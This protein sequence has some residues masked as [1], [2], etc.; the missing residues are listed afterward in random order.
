MQ[1]TTFPIEILIHDDAST[2]GTDDIIREYAEKYPEKI[3]PLFEEK[4]KYSSGYKGKMDVTFNY[5]R[6]RGKYIATCEGDD[7]WT[8]PL[9]LQKQVDFMEAHP[10]FS[11]CWHRYRRYFVDENRWEKDNCDIVL[12]DRDGVDIDLETFFSSWYT[13]PLTMVFRKSLFSFEWSGRYRYY[14]DEHE[15]FHL[16]TVGKGYLLNFDGGVYVLHNGGIYASKNARE[17]SEISCAVAEELYKNN[18]NPY[19]KEFYKNVLQWTVSQH[20]D[21]FWGKMSYSWELFL[22]DKSIKRL[23]KNIMR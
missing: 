6:A 10:D 13:Q 18:E 7:Y 20:K 15:S 23:V 19:T 14:R 8:D 22:L 5:S 2:D 3:L 1:K 21:F 11:V 4:N 16:L 17:Q 12:A 9:K